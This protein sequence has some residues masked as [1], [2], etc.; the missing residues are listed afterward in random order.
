LSDAVQA[1]CFSLTKAL[2][3]RKTLCE[4]NSKTAFSI[5]SRAADIITVMFTDLPENL[6]DGVFNKFLKSKGI[7]CVACRANYGRQ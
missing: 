4:S 5:L 2:V 6:N 3:N 7:Q 1:R